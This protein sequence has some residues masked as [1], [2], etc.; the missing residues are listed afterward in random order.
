MTERKTISV[1]KNIIEQ[2]GEIKATDMNANQP[3]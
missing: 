2:W 3:L 1:S